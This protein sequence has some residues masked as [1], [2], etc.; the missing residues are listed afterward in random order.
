M[1][2]MSLNLL[3]HYKSFKDIIKKLDILNSFYTST[4]ELL[5]QE[6]TALKSNYKDELFV[7]EKLDNLTEDYKNIDD[8]KI[9]DFENTILSNGKPISSCVKLKI[10]ED[11]KDGKHDTYLQ[12][13]KI[14]S[15]DLFGVKQMKEDCDSKFDI[16]STSILDRMVSIF[17]EYLSSIYMLLIIE[18]PEKYIGGKQISLVDLLN[19]KEHP[20]LQAIETEI[21]NQMFDSMKCLNEILKKNEIP[22]SSIKNEMKNFEEIYYRR[23][24]FVHNGGIVNDFYLSG[25]EETT[26]KKGEKLVCDDKYNKKAFINLTNFLVSIEFN[27]EKIINLDEKKKESIS[28]YGFSCL[29]NGKYEIAEH[30]YGLLKTR[31][32]IEHIDRL[33]FFINYLNARKQL[34]YNISKELTTL[35]VSACTDNFKIAKLCLEDKNEEVFEFI[36]KTYPNSFNA[37]ELRDWPIFINFRN[38]TYYETFVEEHRSDFETFKIENETVDEVED[39]ELK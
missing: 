14:N 13:K 24:L 37:I 9:Q 18:N 19:K 3:R 31:K 35:D 10:Y 22:S 36:N 12:M 33:M 29:C 28:D 23:N 32:D 8:Q 34:K 7:I 5:D 4:Y 20:I 25:V 15:F 27:F 38:T 17:E 16:L 11:T 30:I 2:E 21:E 39:S 6:R 1:K 26:F